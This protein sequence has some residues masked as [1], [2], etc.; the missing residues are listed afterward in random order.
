MPVSLV[1]D[2]YISF[3]RTGCIEYT[4][5]RTGV[6]L[7]FRC[8]SNE[9]NICLFYFVFGILFMGTYNDLREHKQYILYKAE[10]NING[11]LHVE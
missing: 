3:I 5:L 10:G 8:K 7:T 9:G 6:E 1:E 4:S 11:K 2:I